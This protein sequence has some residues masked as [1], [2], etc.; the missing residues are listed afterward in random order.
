MKI[1][2]GSEVQEEVYHK[3]PRQHHSSSSRSIK[4][5]TIVEFKAYKLRFFGSLR[6]GIE[7]V[8]EIETD[9]LVPNKI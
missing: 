3:I 5:I 4:V 7:R 2:R 6:F 9:F 1:A 8:S